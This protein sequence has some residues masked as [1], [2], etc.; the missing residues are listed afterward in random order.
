MEGKT[1]AKARKLLE[2]FGGFE[3]NARKQQK[4]RQ[5]RKENPLLFFTPLAIITSS[6]Y[7]VITSM[8]W[9]AST[10]PLSSFTTFLHWCTNIPFTDLQIRH[11]TYNYNTDNQILDIHSIDF[12]TGF[13]VFVRFG[14]VLF[15]HSESPLNHNNW[16][17]L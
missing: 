1:R 4:R 11:R 15:L 3:T 12:I 16:K 8:S 6:I 13:C 5:E 2:R 7:H 14:T 10:L 17:S 9:S